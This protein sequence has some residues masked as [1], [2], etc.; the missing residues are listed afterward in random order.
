MVDKIIISIEGN[1]GVGKSTFINILKNKW[2]NCEIVLEPVEMWKDLKNTDGKNILQ[3]FYEDIP[4]WAYSFQNVAC[5]TRMM[6]IEESIRSTKSKYIFLDRSLGTDKNVFE[7]MLYEQKKLNEIEHSMYNLWCDFYHKYVRPQDNQIY[8]Y[9]KATPE[10]CAQ[11]IKKR[12]RIEE[13]S[14][15]LEYLE[16]LNKYH[17]KW[18]LSSGQENVIVID[19]EEEF[20]SDEIKQEKMII[21]IKNE[22]NLFLNK[23]N[24]KIE[25]DTNKNSDKKKTHEKIILENI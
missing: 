14:I 18:L 1:I 4:R 2:E 20:E 16:G 23:M 3:T 24:N 6:K 11:R 13:E 19:C 12:A 21:K 5:I 17:D 8:I 9:L 15:S 7:A 25:L 22:L 10:T